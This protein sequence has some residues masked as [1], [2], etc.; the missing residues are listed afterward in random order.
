M[1]LPKL[2]TRELRLDVPLDRSN[3][4]RGTI[5]VFARIATAPGGEDRPYAF[6]LQGG[7]GIE[8][9]RPT[10]VPANPPWLARALRDF[11]VVMVD[12]RGTGESTPVGLDAPLPPS[13]GDRPEG[14]AASGGAADSATATHTRT[15]DAP[16]AATLRGASPET[17]AEYLTHFRAD[18]IVGDCEAL[19][20]E[21]GVEQIS[22]IG[23]SFGGFTAVHY[24]SAHAESLREV[25][26]TGGLP[27][28][29]HDPVEVYATTW[30]TMREKSLAFYRDF[31]GTRERVAALMDLAVAGDVVLPN[32]DVVSPERLR[33]LGHLL[34][35]SG[36]AESLYHL[37]QLDH[38]SPAFRH[39]LAA[40]L[41]FGGR[42]PLYA[43]L[44]ESCMAD[45]VATRWA[46]DRAMPDDVR[47]DPTLLAGE[48]VHRSM[49]EENSELRPWAA[50]ADLLA[51]HPW[52]PLYDV[53]ALRRADVP[54]AAAVYF[55]DAYVP[56]RF[57]LETA[58]LLPRARTWVTSEF[59]H[60]G[61]RA[62]GEGVLDHL[63]ALVRGERRA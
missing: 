21:L 19:R 56:T 30:E 60:N 8:A 57:S 32:G 18:E 4:G 31:P 5:E 17:A 40:S 47:D 1:D 33:R 55:H 43:V 10:A 29:G 46:A 12:Q 44:H 24:L 39:D 20:E 15:E 58:G 13:F 38:R 51:D 26:L 6:F 59:E 50:V 11:Q 42:N 25:I 2:T 9:P 49:F 35:A 3:P 23:Q 48:H 41:M 63:V 28:V 61:L 27:P 53:D 22:L 34:G 36:G 52:G 14:A 37:L 54:V 16:T 62:S 45:G 7:P